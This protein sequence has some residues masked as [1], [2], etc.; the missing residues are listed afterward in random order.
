ITV[1]DGPHSK[2]TPIVL[3]LLKANNIKATFFLN[4]MNYGS[5]IENSDVT[6][7]IIKRQV[8]EGHDVGSHTFYHKNCEGGF[9]QEYCEKIHVTYDPR[10]EIVRGILAGDGYRYGPDYG[11][12]DYDIILWSAD[13]EDWKCD[14]TSVTVKDAIASL[15]LSMSP[16][17]ADPSKNSFI[18]LVHDV[19]EYSVTTT[20][21]EIINHVRS[22]GYTFVPLSECIG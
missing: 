3:D 15:D 11:D 7:S 16:E 19:T 12:Y 9:S 5:D 13:P 2:F 8:A 6:K 1:D 14:G 4:G 18:I 17:I 10:T 22:L 21:P 20:I